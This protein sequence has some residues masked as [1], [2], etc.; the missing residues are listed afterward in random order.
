ML[1]NVMPEWD[2]KRPNGV[3]GKSWGLKTDL[4][5]CSGNNTCEYVGHIIIR[6]SASSDL[7]KCNDD[8]PTVDRDVFRLSS[9]PQLCHFWVSLSEPF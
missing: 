8:I 9:A 7:N 4:I 1:E 2:R 6:A 3:K 5:A